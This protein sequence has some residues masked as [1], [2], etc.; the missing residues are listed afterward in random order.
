MELFTKLGINGKLLF[1]QAA[2]FLILF[3]VLKKFVFPKIWKVLEDREA[4]IKE[5]FAMR[6]RAE[7]ELERI[8]TLKKTSIQEARREAERVMHE[9]KNDAERRRQELEREAKSRAQQILDGAETQARKEREELI[10]RAQNS[11]AESVI[12][13]AERV[14]ERSIG[15]H[16]EEKIL[17]EVVSVAKKHT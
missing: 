17:R 12:T 11:I 9:A 6:D 15:A 3:F 8:D 14:L 1:A 13:I 16:D 4:K 2:N 7:G 5:G 10:T